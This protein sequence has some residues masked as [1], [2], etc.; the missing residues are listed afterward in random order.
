MPE[1]DPALENFLN[2]TGFPVANS[3]L[4]WIGEQFLTVRPELGTG[5]QAPGDVPMARREYESRAPPG[6]GA[7]LFYSFRSAG[8]DLEV[9]AT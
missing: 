8:A 3:C 1:T 4:R 6:G 5:R 7:L 9:H 2:R